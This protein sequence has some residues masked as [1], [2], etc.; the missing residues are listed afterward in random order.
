MYIK[1]ERF[2]FKELAHTAVEG[3]KSKIYSVGQK[4]RDSGKS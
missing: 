2:Y 4:A 3:A 1:R